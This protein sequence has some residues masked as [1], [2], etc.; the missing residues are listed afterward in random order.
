MATDGIAIVAYR[1]RCDAC[2]AVTELHQTREQAQQEASNMGWLHLSG[3]GVLYRGIRCQD[4]CH[5]CRVDKY[6][7]PAVEESASE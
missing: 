4:L 2:S 5:A 1:V 7:Q 3:A 6:G